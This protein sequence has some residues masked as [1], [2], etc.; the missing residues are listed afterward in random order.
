MKIFFEGNDTIYHTNINIL[1]TV[2]WLNL[3]IIGL[4]LASVTLTGCA[5]QKPVGNI[6]QSANIPVSSSSLSSMLLTTK[7]PISNISDERTRETLRKKDDNNLG[8]NET[9]YFQQTNMTFELSLGT[10]TFRKRWTAGNLSSYD[11]D[12]NMTIKNTGKIPLNLT[13]LVSEFI[14]DFGDGCHTNLGWCYGKD[15]GQIYPGELKNLTVNITFSST[16]DFNYL[17]SQKY[18]FT[19]STPIETNK[20]GIYGHQ[21]SW[22]I[23]MKTVTVKTS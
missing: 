17:A 5:S 11:A 15:I 9:A 21:F 18:H 20:I 23:D 10:I 14:D 7:L 8:Q 12:I 22:I 6:S 4:L 2:K 19:V 13:M 1:N 3:F 16:K